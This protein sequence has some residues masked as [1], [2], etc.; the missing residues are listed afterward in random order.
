MSSLFGSHCL[1]AFRRA[2]KNRLLASAINKQL[3]EEVD[4][5]PTASVAIKSQRK[6]ENSNHL[7][8]NVSSKL[9]EGYFK[10]AVRVAC[11]EDSFAYFSDATYTPLLL[12]RPSPPP[13]SA[14]PPAALLTSITIVLVSVDEIVQVIRTVLCGSAGGPDGLRPQHLK[15]SGAGVEALLPLLV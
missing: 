12:K 14:I 13:N 11:S 1:A 15:G 2:G 9:K 10:G 7:A 4:A 6:K 5:E 3:N 8:S